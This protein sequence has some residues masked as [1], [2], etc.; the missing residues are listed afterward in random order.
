[1]PTVITFGE[2]MVRLTPPHFQRLEQARTLDVEI[3]GAELNTSVG[4]VRLG[5]TV[6]WASR[7]P[8][9]PLGRLVAA[10]TRE[11]GVDDRLVQ[12]GDGRCGLYWLEVGAA[13]RPSG[14]LYDRKD[15]AMSRVEPGMFDWPTIFAGAKW[16]HTSG[17]T[18][19]LSPGAAAATAE[20]LAAAKSAGVG[21]SFDL[22]YRSKLW[23]PQEAGR[24]LSAMMP[25]V[26]VL[27]ASEGDAKLLFGVAGETFVEVAK[28]MTDRFGIGAVAAGRRDASLVWKD[29][30]GAVGFKNGERIE[31][32]TY[33]CEVVDRLGGGDAF[34]AGLIHGMLEG[35]FAKGLAYGAA[36]G[37]LKHTIPGDLPFV[38]TDEVEAV[39]A[40]QGVR[41]RR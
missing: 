29:R 25:L 9:N 31:T 2:A 12:Y 26:D 7:L 39:L 16:F 5:H 21:I 24:V 6:A 30:V 28:G 1:M 40:G 35:D 17:I 34:A 32:P 36:I 41:I 37:A 3:G 20:A 4:L 14:I 38:S 11:A 15:S 13:P 8:D 23:T 18:A 33:E 22:N 10:R 19:A 27:V